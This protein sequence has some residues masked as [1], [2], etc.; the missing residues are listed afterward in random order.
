MKK[1]RK[2]GFKIRIVDMLC[3]KIF[4]YI[5]IVL[6]QLFLYF[7]NGVPF[8]FFLRIFARFFIIF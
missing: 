4:Y 2:D 7:K 5:P 8:A 1:H 6:I 3:R